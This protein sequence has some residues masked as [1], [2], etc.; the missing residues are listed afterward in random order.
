MSNQPKKPKTVPTLPGVID[1]HAHLNFDDIATDIDGVLARAKAVGVEHI[2][3]IGT[4]FAESEAALETAKKYPN[5]SAT[6]GVHPHDVVEHSESHLTEMRDMCADPSCVAV[7]EIGLDYH[8]DHSPRD[9]QRYWFERQME[10]AREFGLPVVIHTREAE[11]DTEAIL[12]KFPDVTGVMHCYSSGPGLAQKALDMGYMLSF[13]GIITFNKA[14]EVRQIAAD[15]PMDRLMVETD[16]PYLAP[17]PFRG[18]TNEPAYVTLVAQKLAEIKGV[19][20]E[21]MAATT[22]A[23][24]KKL[25]GIN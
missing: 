21:E 1:S 3:T 17:A 16:C 24:T 19:T 7:G 18:K 5:V 22:T 4:T 13:S 25:F 10:L 20:A 23:N 2:V 6:V 15:A 8:Y 9:V 12:K 11:E 14:E